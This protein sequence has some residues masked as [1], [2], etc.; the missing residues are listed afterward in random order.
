MKKIRLIS[1]VLSA[2]LFTQSVAFAAV[3]EHFDS[4]FDALA[5]NTNITEPGAY[6][7][8]RRGVIS[9]GSV[10][11]RSEITKPNI[12][13]FDPPS[14]NAGCNGIS[15][16]GGALSFINGEEF[17]NNLRAIAANASGLLSGYVFKMALSAMCEDC[18]RKI[19]ELADKINAIG[20]SLKNSCEAAKSLV[21]LAPSVPDSWTQSLRSSM[22]IEGSSQ[23]IVG[24]VLTGL[25]SSLN[26]LTAGFD[27]TTRRK[28]FGNVVWKAFQD[29]YFES[30]FPAAMYV[31]DK[32]MEVMMSMTGSVVIEENQDATKDFKYTWIEKTL[33]PY[34]FLAGGNFQ[35][36]DCN[37]SDC[38]SPTTKTVELPGFYGLV[39]ELLLGETVDGSTPRT[40][41]IIAKFRSTEASDAFTER[42]KAFIATMPANIVGLLAENANR[43]NVVA[44]F[45]EQ[46]AINVAEEITAKYIGL[47]IGSIETA[48][49]TYEGKEGVKDVRDRLDKL[50]DEV[51]RLHK[52]SATSMQQIASAVEVDRKVK[53]DIRKNLIAD[54]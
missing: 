46:A 19:T 15:L 37:D 14:F 16:H 20:R 28:Y 7:S 31:D 4:M 49:R 12:I 51:A 52:S 11:M 6:M 45:A 40:I 25:N 10:E 35:I 30:Y 47:M 44:A 50:R 1:G 34:Q 27:S 24:D 21:S 53:Q 5:P 18:E 26:T 13:N 54:K 3:G 48:L 41:G 42:E 43:R 33:D 17:Q 22:S 9:L 2:I 29:S 39:R 36:V 23:G 38:M 32:V 8:A